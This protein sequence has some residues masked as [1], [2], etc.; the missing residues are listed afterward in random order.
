M[1]DNTDDQGMADPFAPENQSPPA[2]PP[3]PPAERPDPRPEC[4]DCGSRM[5]CEYDSEL[6]DDVNPWWC[7]E[8]ALDGLDEPDS[9]Y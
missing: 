6:P 7:P 9:E 2:G 4:P 3:A 8:C 1:H 5:R